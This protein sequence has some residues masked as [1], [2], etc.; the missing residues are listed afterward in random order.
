MQ[1]PT[2]EGIVLACDFCGRDWDMEKPMI[3]G[4]RGSILCIDCLARAIGDAADAGEPF[5]CTMCLRRFDAGGRRYR[6]VEPSTDAN[7]DAVICWDCIQQADRAFGKD[8]QT[9]WQRRIEPDNRWR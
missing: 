2:P 3:E 5:A 8:A 9:D 4:H 7:A 1:R 6:S